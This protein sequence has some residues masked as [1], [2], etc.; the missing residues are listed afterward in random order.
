M[1]ILIRNLSL[2]LVAVSV[3]CF[4]VWGTAGSGDGHYVA[5]IIDKQKSLR[6]CPSPKIILVGGSSLAFGLDSEMI[7]SRVRRPVLNMGLHAGFGLKFMIEE[8]KPYV[9]SGDV[10]LLVPEYEHFWNSTMYGGSDL[11]TV[12][13]AWPEGFKYMNSPGQ[14]IALATSFPEHLAVRW[15]LLCFLHCQGVSGTG[16]SL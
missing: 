12:L 2:L 16:F 1:L 3:S 14:Y 7:E 8:V 13:W 10:V 5:A 9:D 6:S 15:Q 4:G 11:W